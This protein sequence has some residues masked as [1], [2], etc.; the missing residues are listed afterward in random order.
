MWKQ[1]NCM[2]D[3]GWL[4]YLIPFVFVVVLI[5]PIILEIRVSYN[6]IFNRGVVSL[7]FFKINFTYFFV[8]VCNGGLMIENEKTKKKIDIKFSDQKFEVVEELWRQMIDKVKLKKLLMFYSIGFGNA[9]DNAML[10]G[11]INQIIIQIFLF[12]KSKKPTANLG[13]FDNVSYNTST[14][15]IAVRAQIS[16]TFCDLVYSFLLAFIKRKTHKVV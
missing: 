10:C 2:T 13:L 8:S 16:L 15:E 1:N 11:A 7:Y 3:F 9:F 6:P 12:V 4:L 5:F 14:F